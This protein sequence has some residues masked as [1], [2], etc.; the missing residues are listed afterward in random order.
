MQKS[1]TALQKFYYLFD[2][3]YGK[4]KV[5]ETLVVYF[6][7]TDENYNVGFID[8]GNTAKVAKL[9]CDV[10]KTKGVESSLFEITPKQKYPASYNECI[11]KAKEE[12]KAKSRPA[13]NVIS[14]SKDESFDINRY[15]TIYLGYPN[16]WGDVPMCVYTFI[17][18]CGSLSGKTIIPFCTHEG[19]GLGSTESKL[20]KAIPGAAFKS[21][22]AVQGIVA[23][24]DK[25]RTL[26]LIEGWI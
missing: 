21:G 3:L 22:L 10:L 25:K 2:R 24:Q 26:N 23:Q 5:M 16:W 15:D 13:I 12:L 8:E 18:S 9:L 20:K 17:E 4:I 11:A 7:H 1:H 6:S 14:K 19:S